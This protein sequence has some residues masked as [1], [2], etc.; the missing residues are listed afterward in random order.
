[1]GMSLEQFAAQCKTALAS[2]PGP[3]GRVAVT[4]LVQQILQDTDFVETYIPA[5]GPERHVL[6]EDPE[7][8]F[9]ILAHAYEGAK[10]SKPHDHG[11]S[12]A[13]YGQAT[14]ETIMTDYECLARPTADA[15]GQA[16]PVRDYALQPGDA[17]LYEP[18][19]LHSPRRDGSTRLLR[20]EGQNMDRVTRQPYVTVSET[21]SA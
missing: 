17:Y 16:K 4:E 20:I 3:E 14:G 1:M 18:G 7:L 21:V 8:G 5:G 19:V 6:Y 12:W 11:P 2:H 13:I 10:T 9:T 15:P